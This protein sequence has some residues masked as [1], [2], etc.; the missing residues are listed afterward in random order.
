MRETNDLFRLSSRIRL[1]I[2]DLDYKERDNLKN[3]LND[4]SEIYE[5]EQYTGKDEKGGEELFNLYGRLL[6]NGSRGSMDTAKLGEMIDAY[7][8]YMDELNADSEFKKAS[9]FN[10]TPILEVEMDLD[11]PFTILVNTDSPIR[12]KN[13]Q[14]NKYCPSF[15][16]CFSNIKGGNS[17]NSVSYIEPGET[18]SIPLRREAVIFAMERKGEIEKIKGIKFQKFDIYIWRI[19]VP[20][21][22]CPRGKE[23]DGKFVTYPNLFEIEVTKIKRSLVFKPGEEMDT[24]KDFFNKFKIRR[25]VLSNDYPLHDFYDFSSTETVIESEEEVEGEE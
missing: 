4:Y 24:L 20:K 2:A 16:K 15:I 8:N 19:F 5:P 3:I 14:K 11:K 23:E 22:S 9:D 17:K 18:A 21:K 13:N 1:N 6:Y 7:K 10:I 12:I 25:A